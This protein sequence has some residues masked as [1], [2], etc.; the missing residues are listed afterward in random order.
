V[1]WL[2]KKDLDR[3][4]S[5]YQIGEINKKTLENMYYY[6]KEKEDENDIDFMKVCTYETP[7]HEKF[8]K[9]WLEYLDPNDF[10][11]PD[12]KPVKKVLTNSDNEN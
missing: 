8:S 3:I 5:D 9:N 7:M 4:L 10:Y 2:G 11:E 1:D 12:K 6:C